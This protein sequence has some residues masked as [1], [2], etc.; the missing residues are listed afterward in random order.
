LGNPTDGADGYSG[1][2][3]DPNKRFSVW[4]SD[5]IPP[6][7]DPLLHEV[8]ETKRNQGYRD[9]DRWAVEQGYAV[10]LLKAPST[11]VTTKRIGY[12]AFGN[13]WVLPAFWT[14]T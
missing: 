4:K 12:Q 9:F 10:P 3:L 2:I 13:G 5:D 6:R 1:L 7:L 14:L 11:V 8:D